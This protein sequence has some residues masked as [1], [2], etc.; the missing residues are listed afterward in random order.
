MRDRFSAFHYHLD[1]PV[2]KKVLVLGSAISG[3]FL[4]TRLMS[5]FNES[6]IENVSHP[7]Y[8]FQGV[9]IVRFGEIPID[10]SSSKMLWRKGNDSMVFNGI[11]NHQAASKQYKFIKD[12]DIT[13]INI[14]RDI[15][16][17][18]VSKPIHYVCRLWCRSIEDSCEFGDIINCFVKYEDLVTTPDLIQEKIAKDLGLTV[19]HKFSEYP[20]YLPDQLDYSTMPHHNLRPIDTKSVNKKK[21]GEKVN[22]SS[23]CGKYIGQVETLRE[24]LGYA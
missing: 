20:K 23:I 8:Y 4:L 22:L 14:V 6:Y 12:H 11:L 3:T 2:G 15:F 17:V 10:L 1:G 19:K 5:Y 9:K 24:R 16:D 13:V 18:I 21:N 7:K